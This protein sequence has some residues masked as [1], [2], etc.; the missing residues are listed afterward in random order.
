LN[1]SKNQLHEVKGLQFN[2]SGR[3]QQW[4]LSFDILLTKAVLWLIQV[5]PGYLD[6]F[7][8]HEGIGYFF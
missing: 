2:L 7:I 3:P 6:E 8:F 5:S 1:G 4:F